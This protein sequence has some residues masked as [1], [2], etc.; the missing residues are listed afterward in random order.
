MLRQSFWLCVI[1]VLFC[2]RNVCVWHEDLAH[3]LLA[4]GQGSSPVVTPTQ[5]PLP[6]KELKNQTFVLYNGASK[7]FC[8][9]MVVAIDIN[10]TYTNATGVS[11]LAVFSELNGTFPIAA[12]CDKVG[13]AD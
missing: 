5:T 8:L 1:Q 12:K 3:T 6:P 11:G 13:A 2:L 4:L 7:D 10:I 9:R